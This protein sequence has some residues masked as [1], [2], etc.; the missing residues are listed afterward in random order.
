ME[1]I[2]AETPVRFNQALLRGRYTAAV[3]A[4]E[5]VGVPID[6]D[7]WASLERHW[8]TV[9]AHLIAEDDADYGVYVNGSF[10]QARFQ[11]LMNAWGIAWPQLASGA[12]ALDA[13][14]FRDMAAIYPELEKLRLLRNTLADLRRCGLAIGSDGRNRSLLS[15]YSTKTGRN[16]PSS[17]K[18]VFGASSWMRY[19]IK[20]AAGQAI[21]Y[22]DYKSQEV[23][24]VAA[25]AGDQKLLETALEADPYLGFAIVAGLAPPEATKETHGELRQRLKRAVLGSNYGL[26]AEGLARQLQISTA[27]ARMLLFAIEETY[28][29]SHQMALRSIEPVPGGAAAVHDPR[30]AVPCG[31]G[32]AREHAV[33]L[34]GAGDRRRDASPC[35]LSRRRAR[36]AHRGTDP[37]RDPAQLHPRKYPRTSPRCE[38]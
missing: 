8:E 37:R 30:L 27:Q 19:L 26:T 5:H 10:N 11:A 31:G 7:L 22:M 15:P 35:L 23:A 28:P 17:T 16:A 12:P 25:L 33:E 18:F 20:P 2:V 21:A 9:S 32:R 34:A 24:I 29:Q 38:R 1:P 4:M 6:T 36:V 13:D 3:G 14:I